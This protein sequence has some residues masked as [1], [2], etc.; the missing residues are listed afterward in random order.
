MI[1]YIYFIEMFF[2]KGF[3]F[4]EAPQVKKKNRRRMR[5][6]YLV[7]NWQKKSG[8]KLKDMGSS[9]ILAFLP[10]A[11]LK[12]LQ[13]KYSSTHSIWYF[14]QIWLMTVR[15]KAQPT[16]EFLRAC[17]CLSTR[18]IENDWRWLSKWQASLRLRSCIQPKKNNENLRRLAYL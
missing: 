9:K 7:K 8:F 12:R 3:S 4:T 13:K 15:Y 14:F 2:E 18:N 5:K 6:K 10:H 17:L 1:L 16:R 11:T